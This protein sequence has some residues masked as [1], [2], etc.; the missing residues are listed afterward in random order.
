M[1]CQVDSFY[2]VEVLPI[3]VQKLNKKALLDK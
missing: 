2:F 3:Q 1:L